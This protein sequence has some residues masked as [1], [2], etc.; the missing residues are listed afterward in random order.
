MS[1][2]KYISLRSFADIV[3]VSNTAISKAINSGRLIRSVKFGPN[4]EKLGIDPIAG[5]EEWELSNPT[6]ASKKTA[7]E[8]GPDKPLPSGLPSYAQARAVR[9]SYQARIA[10]IIYEEKI[11]KLVD[12]SDVKLKAFDTARTVRDFILNI[13]N[14]ISSELA[15]ETDPSKVHSM[16]TRELTA[17]LDELARFLKDGT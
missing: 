10:K 8:N 11:G 14:R 15:A 9:E 3:G 12:A 13:P 17:S 5:Q 4:G 16:L 1:E 7:A 2:T 6:R